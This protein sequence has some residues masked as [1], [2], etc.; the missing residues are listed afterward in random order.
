MAS[1]NSL[2]VLNDFSGG[3]NLTDLPIGL[4]GTECYHAVNVEWVRTRA[5]RRRRGS[6]QVITSF[7]NPA[8]FFVGAIGSMARHVP[9]TSEAAAEVWAVDSSGTFGR[10]AAGPQFTKIVPVDALTGN[11]WDVTWATVAGE[12]F[13]A[14]KSAVNRLHVWDGATLRRTGLSPGTAVLAVPTNTGAGAYAATARTYRV[15]FWNS[16]LNTL[17]EPTSVVAFTPSGAGVAARIVRPAPLPGEGED[18]WIVEVATDGFSYYQIGQVAIATAFYDDIYTAAQTAPGN[19]FFILSGQTG[20]YNLQKSYRF[21]AGAQNRLL[22]FGTFD[23]TTGVYQNRIEISDIAGGGTIGAIGIPLG[24]P[25]ESVNTLGG[26]Y[27]DLDESDSGPATG[28]AGPVGG[29][30]FAFKARQMWELRPTGDYMKPFAATAIS[31]TIGAVSQQCI[32]VAEDQVGRGAL[33][34]WSHL[35]PYRHTVNGL[36]Y[37]GHNLEGR[38]KNSDSPGDVNLDATLRVSHGIYHPLNRQVWWWLSIAT[39]T[40]P[41]IL[42][43]YHVETGGWA[44]F[45]GPPAH[46]R[47]SAMLPEFQGATMSRVLKPHI[48]PSPV[49]QPGLQLIKCDDDGSAQDAGTPLVPFIAQLVTRVVAPGGPGQLGNVGDLQVFAHGPGVALYLETFSN[50]SVYANIKKVSSVSLTPTTEETLFVL[51]R[52]ED[53]GI[54]EL[55]YV[56]YR[57]QDLTQL[58]WEL[59]QLVVPVRPQGAVIA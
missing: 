36:E 28:L 40:E 42:L 49:Y 12:L 6:A 4:K 14:Y 23:T 48:A 20:T 15:R 43:V 18:F 56:H 13:V 32:I 57:I 2:V 33:Y 30:Y 41:S 26:W 55:L 3:S 22:G 10:K 21:I 9:G 50:V 5:G 34:F 44:E 51:R 19:G 39:D 8:D 58:P 46:A 17:S 59:V 52:F 25:A 27:I 35:G 47:C 29:N 45:S 1:P 54:G 31:K 38:F 7:V 24:R 53:S 11:A 16:L 37:L